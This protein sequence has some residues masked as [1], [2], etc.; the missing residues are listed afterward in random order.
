MIFSGVPTDSGFLWRVLLF[1]RLDRPDRHMRVQSCVEESQN[2][3]DPS[4]LW[5]C[6]FE[7]V[8]LVFL[9]ALYLACLAF[10]DAF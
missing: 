2:R 1:H 9:L 7:C 3:P 6:Q 4:H 10:T 8:V 5:L